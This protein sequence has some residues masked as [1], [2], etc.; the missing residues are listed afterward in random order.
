MILEHLWD[1]VMGGTAEEKK[2][3]KVRSKISSSFKDVK[4]E[5]SKQASKSS[6]ASAPSADSKTKERREKIE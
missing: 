1:L 5:D 2:K 3:S 6:A 4:P